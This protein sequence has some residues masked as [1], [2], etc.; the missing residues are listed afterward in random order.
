MS[1]FS[2]STTTS[3]QNSQGTKRKWVLKEDAVLVVYMVD[4]HNVGTF[5]AYTR[6]KAGYLNE[7]KRM[8]EKTK[9]R[10]TRENAQ[11][12][13]DIVEEIDVEDVATTKNPEKG[14]TYHG[15]QVDASFNEMDV[16]VTQSQSLKP[17]QDDST[18]LK[19][20]KKKKIPHYWEK[21]YGLL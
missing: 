5:N 15:C 3:S 19:K 11:T 20:E 9:N 8:L 1:D 12:A 2:Q 14:S 4:L 13:T 6:F 10:A 16:S 17:N 21:T 7:L 18:F